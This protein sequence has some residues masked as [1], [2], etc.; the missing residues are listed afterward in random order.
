M[1][2]LKP[3]DRAISVYLRFIYV[4][5]YEIKHGIIII[6]IDKKF[7]LKRKQFEAPSTVHC[8]KQFLARSIK[9]LETKT[10]SQTCTCVFQQFF[11]NNYTTVFTFSRQV[12]KN[13]KK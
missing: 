10:F 3:P 8:W 5:P 13:N 7:K 2:R 9:I 11:P 12:I 4:F 6:Y 1:E